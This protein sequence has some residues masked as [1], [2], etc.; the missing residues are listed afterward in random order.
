MAA[1]ICA[2]HSPLMFQGPASSDDVEGMR[3][4]FAALAAFVADYQPDLI[5]QFAPDHLNG[6]LYDII[7]A[8]CLGTKASAIGDWGT[9]AGQ[10]RVP[11]DYS[12][13]LGEHL[14]DEG[15]DLAI[16]HRMVVDHGFTQIWPHTIGSFDR[17]PLIP[18]FVNSA[19]RPLPSFARAAALGQSVGRWA[20][21]QKGKILFCA[22]GG[23]SH[24]PPLP[25]LSKGD[26]ESRRRLLRLDEVTPE[27][28]A[29][30]ERRV[31]EAGERAANG[32]G[33]GVPLNPVFDQEILRK[34]REQDLDALA[35]FDTRE[36]ARIAGS[37]ANELLC[38]LAA[39]SALSQ[40]GRYRTEVEF[41]R[42]IEGW[43]TG[44]GAT[45]ATSVN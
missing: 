29:A 12:L 26:D 9:A 37:G 4:A 35:S 18:V 7:P 10:L 22:S 25:L 3:K 5:I 31:F 17:Y 20:S 19:V 16:S 15:F 6:F 14:L 27:A 43:L 2:S 1:L 41:Y 30:R 40:F 33:S 44:M 21:S 23:L 24:D 28:R 39:Y 11:E 42:P 45:A 36:V 32:H 8:F 13:D 34:L 38:W